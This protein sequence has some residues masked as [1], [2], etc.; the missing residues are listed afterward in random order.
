[1]TTHL[2]HLT[3]LTHSTHSTHF[4][5]LNPLE[6]ETSEC[7]ESKGQKGIIFS[8]VRTLLQ[9][10]PN[11]VG[12]E[13]PNSAW[14]PLSTLSNPIRRSLCANEFCFDIDAKDWQSCYQLAQRLE[15]VFLEWNIAFLRFSSGNWLHYSAFFDKRIEVPNEI[16]LD[17]FRGFKNVVSIED[18]KGFLK[19]LRLGLFKHLVSLTNPNKEAWFDV[20][21]MESS[22]HLIRFE[23]VIHEK[24]GFYKSLLSEL[25]EEQPK[26]TKENVVL[27]TQIEHWQIPEELLYYVYEKFVQKPKTITQHT[28][29]KKR[30]GWIEEL[31]KT[32][33]V[34]GR[35][36][37]VDLILLPYLVNI[38]K[39]KEEEILGVVDDWLEKC[40]ELKHTTIT[41]SYIKSKCRYVLN[42]KMLPLS[43][44]NLGRW[45]SDVPE[46]MEVV[47]K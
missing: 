46:I 13:Y 4:N 34:D 6:S 22:R 19:I 43:K 5:S 37:A 40:N 45:F 38:K 39:L 33:L 25:P 26:I 24:T 9:E 7:S 11:L 42:R 16:W 18:L 36:R 27:P 17:Y 3:H 28:F 47:E 35:C 30:I 8:L 2:T 14:L 44:E 32:P 15:N 23:G 1:M 21:V 29:D 31:L 41:D 12:Q 20:G 10:D